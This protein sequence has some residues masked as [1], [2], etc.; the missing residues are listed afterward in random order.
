MP[1]IVQQP[2]T[3]RVRALFSADPEVMT[4]LLSDIEIHSGLSRLLREGGLT[5]DGWLRATEGFERVWNGI[6]VI[7][8]VEAVKPRARRVLRLHPLRAAGA[9]QLGA[10]L[11]SVYD[12]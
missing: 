6:T 11:A 8:M 9:L 2:A 7:S 5:R 4:W 3:P 10:A 1:L 12:Q